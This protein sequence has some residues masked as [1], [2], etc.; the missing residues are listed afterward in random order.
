MV[1][2]DDHRLPFSSHGGR[3]HPWAGCLLSNL[4]ILIISN[5][6]YQSLYFC[7]CRY[8]VAQDSDIYPIKTGKNLESVRFPSR[9]FPVDKHQ[10]STT[11][12]HAIVAATRLSHPAFFSLHPI[13]IR[14]IL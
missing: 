3:E 7:Y 11:A 5:Y 1:N 13:L 4:H 9:L 8:L 10:Y 12:L 14:S 2:A 6:L